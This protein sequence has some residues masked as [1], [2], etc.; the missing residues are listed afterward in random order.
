MKPS[1]KKLLANQGF[2][3]NENHIN[4]AGFYLN[5]RPSILDPLFYSK[6]VFIFLGRDRD[7]S[8]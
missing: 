5:N 3:E 8:N 4:I 1:V 2:K 6:I 7:P